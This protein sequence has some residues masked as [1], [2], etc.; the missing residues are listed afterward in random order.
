MHLIITCCIIYG[1][2]PKPSSLYTSDLKT[3]TGLHKIEERKKSFVLVIIYYFCPRDVDLKPLLPIVKAVPVS[4]GE[5][6]SSQNWP[7]YVHPPPERREPHSAVSDT[8]GRVGVGRGL[9]GIGPVCTCVYVGFVP[10]VCM[11]DLQNGHTS[12]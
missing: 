5:G 8:I 3:K 2:L 1:L 6:S 10:G 9:F 4:A 12:W 7:L 11:K